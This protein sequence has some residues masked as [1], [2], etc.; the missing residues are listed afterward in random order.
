[1]ASSRMAAV[2]ANVSVRALR[3]AAE[4]GN[5]GASRTISAP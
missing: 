5:A 1:M 4:I 2:R 3:R